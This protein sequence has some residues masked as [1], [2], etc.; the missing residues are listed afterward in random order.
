MNPIEPRE[1]TEITEPRESTEITE[2]RE[3]TEPLADVVER[4][5]PP[6]ADVISHWR[7]Q[8]T[9]ESPTHDLPAD[10]TRWHPEAWPGIRHWGLRGDGRLVRQQETVR[11]DEPVRQGEPVLQGEPAGAS[12]END[13][14]SPPDAHPIV[15]DAGVAETLPSRERVATPSRKRIVIGTL[16]AGA[17]LVCGIAWP[18]LF[19]ESSAS[20]ST[21]LSSGS[22]SSS[23]SGSGSGS[24]SSSSSSS[25]ELAELEVLDDSLQMAN[26]DY[27][28]AEKNR[29]RAEMDDWFSG[30]ATQRKISLSNLDTANRSAN[31]DKFE[32]INEGDDQTA[33]DDLNLANDPTTIKPDPETQTEPG[34]AETLPGDSGA[35][36]VDLAPPVDDAPQVDIASWDFVDPLPLPL[37]IPHPT[38]NPDDM[39]LR[40]DFPSDELRFVAGGDDSTTNDSTTNDDAAKIDA[41]CLGRIVDSADMPLLAI[42]HGTASGSTPRLALQP[43]IPRAGT[44]AGRLLANSRLTCGPK[45]LYLRRAVVTDAWSLRTET[46]D[47]EAVWDLRIAPWMRDTR[48]KLVL[49]WPETI[50]VSWLEAPTDSIRQTF[51]AVLTPGD[52][53]ESVAL[54]LRGDLRVGRKVTLRLRLAARVDPSAQWSPI[55]RTIFSSWAEQWALAAQGVDFESKR[56]D[57][58]ERVAYRIAGYRGEQIIRDKQQLNNR[59]KDWIQEGL[60][61]IGVLDQM[62]AE[63]DANSKVHLSVFRDWGNANQQLLR[64]GQP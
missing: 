16:A 45:S 57:E 47:T 10:P 11:Q 54:G 50:D 44:V 60:R 48:T 4:L 58:V 13:S 49:D 3:S 46:A 64:V 36:Q 20:T 6:P 41:T 42:T 51:V 22:S 2:P 59:R 52:E 26:E 17:L 9:L 35:P 28:A 27:K 8:A 12:G 61:R 5:G 30:D 31:E 18:Y 63:F 56:L 15:V 40:F 33:N 25:S 7:S 24:S 53:D 34:K 62:L 32:A 37:D 39:L 14:P 55:S 1:S 23:G 19:F 29:L 43:L 21:G 38:S